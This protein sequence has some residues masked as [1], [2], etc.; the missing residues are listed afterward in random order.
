MD[1]YIWISALSVMSSWIMCA[2]LSAP[3]PRTP[4]ASPDTQPRR[5]V[6]TKRCSCATFLDNECVYFCHL[7]IIWVNTPERVVAYGLGSAP[8]TRR[9][10]SD[11]RCQ[12]LRQNDTTCRNFCRP[13]SPPRYETS[14]DTAIRAAEAGACAGPQ[15]KHKLAGDSGPMKRMKSGI[16]ERV[17]PV[18]IRAPPSLLLRKWRERQRHRSRAWEGE[19]TAS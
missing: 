3:A 7:D 5:H 17:S 8:R 2:V 9:A 11:P 14:S 1:M 19:G 6:R 18:A 12:C 13:E 10:L 16:K 4:T 15:C